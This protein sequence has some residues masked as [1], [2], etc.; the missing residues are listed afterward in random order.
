[1]KPRIFISYK[2]VDKDKVFRIKD[3]IEKETGEKCWIDLDGIESDAQ[4]KNVIINAINNSEIVLF[5]YSKTH[6]NI[7]DFEKDWT[8]RELNFASSKGKRIVF[9]NI[10]G[11]PLTDAFAFDYSTKQ[12]VDAR[13]DE[14]MSRL[15]S[16]IKK[17]LDLSSP[18]PVN[19][20]E[21]VKPTTKP[22]VSKS[23]I[24][25]PGKTGQFIMWGFIALSLIYCIIMNILGTD[26]FDNLTVILCL[27]AFV[28]LIVGLS[29]PSLLLLKQRKTTLWYLLSLIFFILAMANSPEDTPEGQD[30]DYRKKLIAQVESHHP[31]LSFMS[32]D[33]ITIEQLEVI[34]NIFNNM[35]DVYGDS[36]RFSAFETSVAEYNTIIGGTYDKSNASLPITDINFGE[37]NL[38][39]QKLNSLINSDKAGIEFSL[40]NKEEWEY[41]ASDGN[42]DEGFIYSGS[43]DINEVA[44]YIGNS[45]GKL[46]PADG[47]SQL[48]PNDF[49]LYDMSGNVGEFVFTPYIDFN[50]PNVSSNM[51]L[52]KGGNFTSSDNDCTIKSET[53]IDTDLS[54]PKVGFRLTLRK[55]VN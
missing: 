1:M 39:I 2:R 29:N 12:Q 17:W 7:T 40:P 9:V 42:V 51:M 36:I 25:Q 3:R 27:L 50:N 23:N 43:N 32:N 21:P 15:T 44:W 33:S 28:I 34:D 49:G 54:S 6:S 18:S 16:D 19:P 20:D 52:V 55:I 48:K 31:G 13:S 22:T 26:S 30:P 24:F 11:S 37:V 5:M 47:Q 4:F 46:H 38:F 45:E 35:R 53:P 14:A 41:A 8:V 10:D